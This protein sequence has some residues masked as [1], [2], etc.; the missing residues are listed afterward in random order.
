MFVAAGELLSELSPSMAANEKFAR[1]KAAPYPF[2]VL[3][4]GP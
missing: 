4:F 2:S 3:V 1:L